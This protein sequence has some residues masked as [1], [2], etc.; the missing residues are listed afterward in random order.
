MSGVIMPRKGVHLKAGIA[1]VPEGFARRIDNVD[2]SVGDNIKRRRG[3]RVIETDP[4]HSMHRSHKGVLVVSGTML[5]VLEREKR[6]PLGDLGTTDPTE[7]CEYNENTYLTN[8]VGTWML[9]PNTPLSPVGIPL[10]NVLP[11]VTP[12]AMGA[13]LPGAYGI[14]ISVVAPTG[15]E[16]GAAFLGTVDLPDGGGIL[17][18]G[19]LVNPNFKFRIHAT[20]ADGDVMYF[21]EEIQA[22]SPTY[23]ITRLTSGSTVT[24]TSLRPLP[25]GDFICGYNGRLYI[26]KG[27]TIYHSQALRPHLYDP[28]HD[29]I[30]MV[31][32]VRFMAA[33]DDGI[34]VG[35]DRGV[36]F[37]EGG[38]VPRF[39]IRIADTNRA[40]KRSSIVVP[41]AYFNPEMR[42]FGDEVVIW[43]SEIGYILGAQQGITIPL[44]QDRVRVSA[45]LEGRS[46]L[47]IRDGIKQIITLVAS[48]DIFGYGLASDQTGET[49]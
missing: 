30:K 36:V 40:V 33:T 19:L 39:K 26:A 27:D 7:F 46:R 43:L 6:V 35:D 45:D 2:V 10:P 23:T 14:A 42:I 1:G 21:A 12:T 15:E 11:D 37:L 29:F 34:Y 22:T 32:D 31:G 9:A 44:Q 18:T 25:G 17:I 5:Y 13:L 4:S 24:N 20:S 41:R 48:T 8:S 49:Q 28:R 3:Y 16:S 47:L 38:D